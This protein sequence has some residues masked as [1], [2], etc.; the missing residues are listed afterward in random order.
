[1]Q[2]LDYDGVVDH[3]IVSDYN[4][5]LETRI[6]RHLFDNGRSHYPAMRPVTVVEINDAWKT[7]LALRC[8]GNPP[9][10]H[11]SFMAHGDY[12]GFLGDDD[13]YLKDH[14][15]L[16]VSTM[17]RDETD[18][19]ISQVAFYGH[20]TYAIT[21]GDPSFA[22]GHL[23]ANGIMCRR[24]NLRISNWET[25]SL[26]EQHPNAGDWRMVRDWVVAGLSGS[27]IPQVTAKHHDGWL[28]DYR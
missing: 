1:V 10:R 20:G 6:R 27:F 3:I 8:R 18:F 5:G 11:G 2:D 12:V 23:D 15:E 24:Q 21:V 9:W 14:V 19:T 22:H 7:D 28:T 26:N 4:P 13:E 25:A 16:A 17:E